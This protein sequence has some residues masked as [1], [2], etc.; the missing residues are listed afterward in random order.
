MVNEYGPIPLL[1]ASTSE[2]FIATILEVP[3]ITE[4]KH[5]DAHVS[6]QVFQRLRLA[7]PKCEAAFM[8][9]NERDSLCSDL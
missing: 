5:I 9:L 3:S 8:D 7:P 1:D 2:P 6:V 4:R